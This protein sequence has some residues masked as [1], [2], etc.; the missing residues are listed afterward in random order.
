MAKPVLA[1]ALM[2]SILS[3]GAPAPAGAQ[4]RAV[5][6]DGRVQW[7]AGQRMVVQL[8]TGPSVS[9]ELARVPQDEYAALT[10][11]E[12]VVISGV[13]TD[14]DSRDVATSIERAAAAQ[15]P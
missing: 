11:G 7:V 8:D 2:V 1:V 9:V 4:D 6:F 10:W 3:M 14:T 13:I 12:R 15:A 5:R